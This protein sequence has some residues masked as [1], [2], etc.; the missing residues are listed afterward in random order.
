MKLRFLVKT[1]YF[2]HDNHFLTIKA[3][4]KCEAALELYNYLIRHRYVKNESEI[5]E[6]R[7]LEDKITL[8]TN[9]PDGAVFTFVKE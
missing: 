6:I 3:T 8:E 2:T 9:L 7:I 4:D 1:I 5:I